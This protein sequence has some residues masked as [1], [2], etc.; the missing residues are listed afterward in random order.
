[1]CGLTGETWIHNLSAARCLLLLPKGL[2]V[3]SLG[4]S[5]IVANEMTKIS[6]QSALAAYQYLRDNQ[7]QSPGRPGYALA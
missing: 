4:F 3:R 6:K 1:M 2:F 7:H 5:H